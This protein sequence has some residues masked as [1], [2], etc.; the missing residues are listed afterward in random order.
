MTSLA[1]VAGRPVAS[2]SAEAVVDALNP[3]GLLEVH[4]QSEDG[5]F[6]ASGSHRH[7][8]CHPIAFSASGDCT[9]VVAGDIINQDDVD[10]QEIRSSLIDRSAQPECL[11]R[12]RGS[13]AI[14]VVDP[15]GRQLWIVTDPSCWLPV[16]AW[17]GDD[18]AVISTSL[19]ATIRSMPGPAAVSTDWIFE[20]LYFNHGIGPTTPCLLYTSPSPRD[21]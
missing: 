5:L 16:N 10:W 21:A 7:A 17:I 1:V 2:L 15:S 12:L 8:P 3:L 4:T 6:I 14:M 18:G 20:N 13:F 11:Q 9:F 19:A